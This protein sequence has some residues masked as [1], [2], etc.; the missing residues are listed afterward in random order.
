LCNF[1]QH[2]LIVLPRIDLI[3]IE[4]SKKLKQR[5]LVV[6]LVVSQEIKPYKKVFGPF[7]HNNEHRML[8]NEAELSHKLC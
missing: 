8:K 7:S 5:V 4:N 2:N 6:T 1:F 3:K